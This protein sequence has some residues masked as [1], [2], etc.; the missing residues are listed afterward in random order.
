M[1]S[2]NGFVLFWR[3]CI[4]SVCICYNGD[5]SN[6]INSFWERFFIYHLLKQ[7]IHEIFYQSSNRLGLVVD[8]YE[9]CCSGAVFRCNCGA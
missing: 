1:Y 3:S 8:G 5:F 7:N 9:D 4:S 6:G 2:S